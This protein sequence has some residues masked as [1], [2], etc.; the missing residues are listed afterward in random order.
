[1]DCVTDRPSQLRFN[2]GT[3]SAR[4]NH[5][6]LDI[7]VAV[8]LTVAEGLV[9]EGVTDNLSC[10]GFQL[11]GTRGHVVGL[12]PATLQPGPRERQH[13]DVTLRAHPAPARLPTVHSRCAAVFAR[14]TSETEY[15]IGFEF[16]D[17][18]PAVQ[19]WVEARIASALRRR[20]AGN[21]PL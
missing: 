21:G 20:T 12:F 6:R 15:Q 4:R 17:P 11:R 18:A 7:E 2:N 13:V 9:L 8:R 19:D 16:V 3:M 5:P 10:A 14:R 1:M